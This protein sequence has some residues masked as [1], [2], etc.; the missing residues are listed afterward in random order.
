MQNGRWHRWKSKGKVV[1][2]F[3]VFLKHKNWYKVHKG[4]IKGIFVGSSV[5]DYIVCESLTPAATSAASMVNIW[6]WC[7]TTGKRHPCVQLHGRER[8]ATILLFFIFQF[9]KCKI[10]FLSLV[11]CC[12]LNDSNAFLFTSQSGLGM[13]NH[14]NYMKGK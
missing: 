1:V 3:W 6:F 12:L 4:K 7:Q 2:L 11:P 8:S 13:E 10:V 9:F 14:H 5:Q